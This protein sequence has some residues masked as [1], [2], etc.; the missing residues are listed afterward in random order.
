MG[1][2]DLAK[3]KADIVIVHTAS[4]DWQASPSPSVWRKRL[5]LHGPQEAGRVTSVVRYEPD[6]QFPLHG[7]PDGE[8]ILVLSGT[9][10][11][12][13][14]DYGA[15]SFLLNPEGFT[16]APFSKQGCQLFVK[17]RQY[18]GPA[19]SK[20]RRH[21]GDLDWHSSAQ[22]GV[23]LAALYEEVGH[24][25]CMRVLCLEAGATARLQNSHGLEI[26]VLEGEFENVSDTLAVGAWGRYPPDTPVYLRTKR[27]AR[28]YIKSGHLSAP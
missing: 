16:H 19:R 1:A 20:C 14:G 15:G 2:R 13:Y 25:E 3:N 10:S 5:E 7:H 28:C 21:I 27:G 26:F 12:E 9:F 11:D 4:L 17:L 18:P 24:P 22:D 8:E 6:S 23:W